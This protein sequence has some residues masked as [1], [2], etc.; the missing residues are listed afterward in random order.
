MTE[1][2]MMVAINR[3]KEAASARPS[4]ALPRVTMR[5]LQSI[6]ELKSAVIIQANSM[7]GA[8][9][10]PSQLLVIRRTGILM[11]D[12]KIPKYV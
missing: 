4:T 10:A 7:E 6:R 8:V 1:P 2:P 3:P 9:R 11:S 12:G 5:N